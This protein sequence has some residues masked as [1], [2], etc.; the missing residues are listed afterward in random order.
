[1]IFFGFVF[2]FACL[3]LCEIKDRLQKTS[4]VVRWLRTCLQCRG[5]GFY[6]LSRKIPY[7]RGRLSS[8][9]TTT[10]P[11]CP[12]PCSSTVTSPR[13]SAGEQPPLATTRESLSA[14]MKTQCRKKKYIKKKK[15]GCRVERAH[16]VKTWKTSVNPCL[17][18][19]GLLFLK[20][21][22]QR[23]VVSSKFNPVCKMP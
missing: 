4:L 7:A 10:E 23:D 18:D 19:Q 1:M 13:T 8:C 20:C 15:A 5:H 9:I 22:S 21:L 2:Y 6:P 16:P 14:A 11:T 17:F 12:Q 3:F